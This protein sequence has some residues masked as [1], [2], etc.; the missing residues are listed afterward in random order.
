MSAS[1]SANAGAVRGN[2]T[3]PQPFSFATEKRALSGERQFVDGGN[4]KK[5]ANVTDTQIK[6]SS[7][8]P[9]AT[10]KPLQR[11]NSLHSDGEDIYSEILTAPSIRGSRPGPTVATAPIFR[12]T[13]RAVKR[14][15]F[16]SKLEVKQQAM[17][18]EKSQLEARMKEEQEAALKQHR[19]SLVFKATPL[20]SFYHEG[21]PP[22]VELKKP[23]PTRAKSPKIGRRKSFGDETNLSQEDKSGGSCGRMYRHNLGE[24]INNVQRPS[25][26]RKASGKNR[27]PRLRSVSDGSIPVA[28]EVPVDSS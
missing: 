14:K 15:E 7:N 5:P 1:R 2:H 23:P 24:D 11:D 3:V 6:T 26:N 12:S 17:E 22:A 21:P 19:K 9:I 4:G 27:G 20:P 13:E 18:A 10:R 25:I 28:D 16:Y 8:L